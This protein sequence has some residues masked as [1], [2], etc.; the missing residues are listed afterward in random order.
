LTIPQT[1][2][3]HDSIFALTG[4]GGTLAGAVLAVLQQKQLL[5]HSF[6]TAAS[7]MICV[8]GFAGVLYYLNLLPFSQDLC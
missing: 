4:V 3:H 1:A 6:G 2:L 8:G 7:C 5:A